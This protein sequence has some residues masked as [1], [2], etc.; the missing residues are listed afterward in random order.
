M[1]QVG[2]AGKYG[3]DPSKAT[4]SADRRRICRQ[5]ALFRRSVGS[6]CGTFK[7]PFSQVSGTSWLWLS[8]AFQSGLDLLAAC[9]QERR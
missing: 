8:E 1:N 2:S 4:E 9:F 5:P 3:A 7:V 6:T